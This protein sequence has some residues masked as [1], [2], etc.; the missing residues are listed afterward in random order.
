MAYSS[1]V[2]NSI[3]DRLFPTIG[4][5]RIDTP[6]WDDGRSM[7]IIN[8]YVKK[9][10]GNRYY[11][12]VRQTDRFV[13][14]IYVGKFKNWD[15]LDK[16]EVY[17]YDNHRLCL[18]GQKEFDKVFYDEKIIDETAAEIMLKYARSGMVLMHASSSQDELHKYIQESIRKSHLSVLNDEGYESLLRTVRLLP[19]DNRRD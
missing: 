10:N 2:S 12:G 19:P 9:E 5:P 4:A 16:V 1:S 18:I 13:I 3:I 6:I 7:F 11:T 15:Y 8:E 17:V 14:N